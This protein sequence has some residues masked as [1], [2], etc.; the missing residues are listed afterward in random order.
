MV[1]VGLFSSLASGFL[2]ELIQ[3]YAVEHASV[4]FE[5]VE[6]DHSEHV[7]AIR[8]HRLDIAFL[9]GRA[10]A[11]GWPAD[12]CEIAH[13]WNE[14]VYTV[15]SE[16]DELALK[17]MVEW[18]DLRGRDFVVSAAQPASEIYAFLVKHLG[19]LG[20]SPSIELQAVYR[21]TLMQIVAG[22][23]KLTLTSEATIAA[24]FPGVVY[25]RF[26][27]SSVLCGVVAD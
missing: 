1:R 12:G 20:R 11:D 8:Q 24:Q 23:R 17:E 19:R 21:D 26:R 27:S 5:F 13:L 14:R 2:A 22:S 9:T 7:A 25:R 16:G 10:P 3:A 15:M 4:R 6:G 18:D